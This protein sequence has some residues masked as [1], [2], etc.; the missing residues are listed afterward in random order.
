MSVLRICV[1]MVD[2]F[3]LCFSFVYETKSL[4][5]FINGLMFKFKKI[6][7]YFLV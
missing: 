5:K 4:L 6:T 2:M 3:I 7:T 1:K